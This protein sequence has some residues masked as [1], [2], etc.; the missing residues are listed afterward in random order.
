MGE[1]HELLPFVYLPFRVTTTDARPETQR[2]RLT[3]S[4]AA[5]VAEVAK[6]TIALAPGVRQ[7][8]A[9]PSILT[10]KTRAHRQLDVAP[11]TSQRRNE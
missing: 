1:L 10:R 2:N 4:V 7:R 5:I 3:E 11:E 8:D 6:L 9:N